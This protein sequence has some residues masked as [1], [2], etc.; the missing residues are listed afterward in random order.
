LNYSVKE[1]E[2]WSAQTICGSDAFL[3]QCEQIPG[4][5]DAQWIWGYFYTRNLYRKNFVLSEPILGAKAH[6]ICDNVFD[7][8]INGNMVSYDAKEVDV[9]ITSL[10]CN[11]T[12]AIAIRAFQTARLDRFTSGLCGKIE[13]RTPLGTVTVVTDDTWK[14]L[15]PVAFSSNEEPENWMLAE[16]LSETQLFSSAIHPRQIK[17][18]L[19][20]RRKFVLKDHVR[21]ASLAVFAQG[22]AE[23]YMNGQKAQ[24]EYF[25]QGIIQKYREYHTLDV[26]RFLRPGE[27]VLGAITG[28]TW[29]NSQSHSGTFNRRNTLLAELTVE[30]EN[31]EV[32]V[33]GT[34]RSFKVFP[35]PIVDNHLQFG[36]RYD[37]RLEVDGW[38]EPDFDDSHWSFAQEW[39][40][41]HLHP[42]VE[43]CYPPI[44]I[45]KILKPV[46]SW[47]MGKGICYDFG[48]NS[49]GTFTIRLKDTYPGQLVKITAAEQLDE[50]GNFVLPSYAPVFYPED[51]KEN[52]R[53]QAAVKNYNVYLCRGGEE[54][55]T[56]RFTFNGF[57]YLRVEGADAAQILS[58]VYN[59]LYNDVPFAWDIACSD[60]FY[61]SFALITERA[62][63]SN[64]FNGF[65]DCPTREK[66]FWTGDIAFFCTTACFMADCHQLLARW[67]D[68]GRKMCDKVYGW[69][70]EI[71]TVPLELYYFYG[72]KE[73]LRHRWPVILNYVRGRIREANGIL[74]VNANSPFND[75]L[76]PFRK[77]LDGDYFAGCFYCFMLK[78]VEDIAGILGES[79]IQEEFRGKFSEAA[80]AF[81]ETYFLPEESDYSPRS[82]SGIVLP[83]ALGI[84]PEQDREAVARRLGEYIREAGCLT[85]GYVGTRL[86]MPVL[87]D[88]GLA[89][90]V[91]FLLANEKFPSWRHLLN[92]GATAMTEHWTGM[93]LVD[94]G[95]S[96]KNHFS[97]G[98]LVGWM[99]EYLGG[100]RYRKSEPGM[101]KIWLEPF[102]LRQIG[103]F[104]VRVETQFGTVRSSWKYSDDAVI[105][106]FEVPVCATLFLPDGTLTEY[107]AGRHRVIWKCP[108]T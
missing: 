101:R 58:I 51:Y 89:Q 2:H 36:E 76:N 70:D 64:L 32:F 26:T 91:A 34:D 49:A 27:N 9:D 8:Y 74:P 108:E 86:L 80:N 50:D 84:T 7:L 97:L 24:Q 46:K 40:E 63:Q 88:H 95:G 23:I 47:P 67:T 107:P 75:H 93:D 45:Q 5:P 21:R 61:K 31:G 100:I 18:S 15:Y 71:Y 14:S 42:Y 90:T 102:F 62:M 41:D 85:T 13:V 6:F 106:D 105:Y 104:A 69:G 39:E 78:C 48:Y 53:A 83:L 59:V 11:G 73:F 87:C 66:N 57:R 12:N 65:M 28:N 37:A 56:P 20:V 33:L 10:L 92:T 96:S 81:Q 60:P 1:K 98:S 44:K 30:Y 16:G 77:N 68:A 79:E 82:Q 94:R 29:Y 4:I 55:Y 103:D 52:G 25:T 43:K 22:E 54:S 17:R 72:D 3:S 19:Y 99:F 38:C 35:S